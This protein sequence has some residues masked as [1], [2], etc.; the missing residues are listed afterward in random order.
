MVEPA[1]P[2]SLREFM[3]VIWEDW[4]T[5]VT[6]GLSVPFTV[7]ALISKADYAKAIWGTCAFIGVLATIYQVWAK[8]RGRVV[9]LEAELNAEADMRGSVEIKTPIR[10]PYA[11]QSRAGSSLDFECRCANHGRKPCQVAQVGIRIAPAPDKGLPAF[12]NMLTLSGLLWTYKSTEP[13]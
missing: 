13:G 11:D 12:H 3:S 9:N 4:G 5:R 1:R 2:A 7:M 10:N 8:E 6:G